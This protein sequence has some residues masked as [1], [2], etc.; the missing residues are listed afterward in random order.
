MNLEVTLAHV[1]PTVPELR[2]PAGICRHVITE[3]TN[4]DLAHQYFATHLVLRITH[5]VSPII[6]GYDPNQGSTPC[7][8]PTTHRY[9]LTLLREREEA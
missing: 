1:G 4:R 2:T 7:S 8:P 6:D 5:H 9:G 3:L